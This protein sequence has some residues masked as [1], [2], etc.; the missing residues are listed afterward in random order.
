[1]KKKYF[2]PVLLFII[3]LISFFL[4]ARMILAG[5]FFYLADQARD[6]LLVQDI[7]DNRNITLIGT[8]SGLGG[9]F[10]GPLW[11]YLLTP[12]YVLGGGNP[13]AFTYA[14]FIVSLVTVVTGYFVGTWLYNRNIGLVLAFLLA[15]TPTIWSY[16][17]NTIGVN[18][19]PLVFLLM[20]YFLIKYIRG[21]SKSYI[22]AVFFA[23]LSLQFETA[24]PL[25]MLPVVFVSF[26]LNKKTLHKPK[27][28]LL[29]I[30]SFLI[31]VS[32]FIVFELRHDFLMTRS[33][34]S[35]F[36]SGKHEQGYLEIMPRLGSHIKGLSAVYT[37]V[38]VNDSMIL[39]ILL[40]L[41][42]AVFIF[43]TFKKKLYKEKYFKEFLYLLL[44]PVVIFCFYLF[45]PY[46]IFPEYTLGL[47]V[48]VSLAIL[49]VTLS[50]WK[51]KW[52]KIAL[53]LFLS[54]SL[55]ET[56]K[57]LTEKYI[58]P[59]EQDVTSGSYKN[60]KEV[61]DW[62]FKDSKGEKFG[63]YVYTAATFTYGMDYLMW[64][65]SQARGLP[66]PKSEK[67]PFTYLILYPALT[68]DHGAHAFWKTYK[69]NTTATVISRKE[70]K[71]DIIVEKL[72]IKPGEKAADPS[73][74][75]NLIFR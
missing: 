59:Y 36:I 65:E 41:I 72:D 29:S 14:Y 71:G 58:K 57:L 19:V 4:G 35:V 5:D 16:V 48:P 31:S 63:Y 70:F 74:Y 6:Y 25:V 75:Q 32:T 2:L 9:F 17:P 21:D 20:F 13:F 33:L 43:F 56:G 26:F 8:H 18:L 22:F 24:L 60:Q 68:N 30:V 40:L 11:L 46:P 66:Q 47:F 39:K 62:I 7:V 49:F 10:H 50:L 37:S 44:F 51:T 55:F 64:W 27:V 42:F 67:L 54:V 61:A 1:M 12:F 28:I 69:I 23:G 15:I 53:L 73:Y 45:Y 38:L 34:Q 3:I 52:G